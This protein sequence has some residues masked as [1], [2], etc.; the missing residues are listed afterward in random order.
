MDA[1]RVR[2]VYAVLAAVDIAKKS[3][4]YHRG[5]STA[6]KLELT[7]EELNSRL[8]RRQRR[9]SHCLLVGKYPQREAV[10]CHDLF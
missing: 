2:L 8:I 3:G 5:K 10:S 4:R 1:T 7:T 9:P 6:L